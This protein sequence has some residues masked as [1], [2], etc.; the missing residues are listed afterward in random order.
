MPLEAQITIY[1]AIAGALGFVLWRQSLSN[2]RIA[3]M[4]EAF[5]TVSDISS[6]IKDVKDDFEQMSHR[7]DV[8]IKTELD[9]FKELTRE[10]TKK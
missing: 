7:F 5:K 2:E 9:S 8:F 6:D 3:K 1:I 4:E 10:L